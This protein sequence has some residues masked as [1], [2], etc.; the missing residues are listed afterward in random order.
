MNNPVLLFLRATVFYLGYSLSLIPH[1]TLCVLLGWMLPI[2][3]RYHYFVMWNTFTIWWLKVTCGVRY[4]IIGIENIPPHP[5]VLLS[6]HQSPWETIF[7][8]TYFSPLC[9]TLKRE[10]LRIPFFGWAIALLNPIAIDRS[11]RIEARQ[12][13]LIEGQKRLADGIS[14]LV[15]PEGT[16]VAPGEERKFSRGGTELAIIA[17]AIIL[18]VAH[19]AG[20]CWP[21]HKFLKIPGTIDVI[22]GKP[23]PAKGR[24]TRE[25]TEEVQAWTHAML[26]AAG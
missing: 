18:P 9:A 17:E 6:N 3:T 20:T 19:N 10:L 4:R 22:I 15:F 16:R 23:I 8:Y 25:L 5:F 24:E 26:R 11:K 2:K 13:L 14:V 12:T 7:L 21:S 1:A